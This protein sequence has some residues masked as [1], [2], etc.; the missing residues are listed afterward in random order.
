M[1]TKS[2][3]DS[4]T[5]EPVQAD[6]LAPCAP[7][8]LRGLI[9]F[10]LTAW[11]SL[12]LP[13]AFIG[14]EWRV[15]ALH[16]PFPPLAILLAVM[17]ASIVGILWSGIR[18]LFRRGRRLR[19][20]ALILVGLLAPAV[21]YGPLEYSRR[22]WDAR[23]VPRNWA[24]EYSKVFGAALMEGAAPFAYPHSLESTD[25][26]MRYRELGSPEPDLSSMQSHVER[27]QRLLG[28]KLKEKVLWIRGPLT[29]AT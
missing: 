22:A 6:S 9:R 26:I 4:P 25:I 12:V 17:A 20:L 8:P 3:P 18:G 13:Y 11:L 10:I 5:S 2:P 29:S 21:L 28:G 19:T 15:H 14:A 7:N 24:T 1:T 23:D 16:P 27:L